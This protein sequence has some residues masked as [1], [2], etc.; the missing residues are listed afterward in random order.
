MVVDIGEIAPG[1]EVHGH[2]R[3]DGAHKWIDEP[4]GHHP[5]NRVRPS[6]HR[7]RLAD[8]GGIAAELVL[9]QPVTDDD[10]R[11]C[12]LL[13]ALQRAPNARLYS[14]DV[15]V[16]RTHAEDADPTHVVA[17]ADVGPGLAIRAERGDGPERG[18]ALAVVEEVHRR[19]EATLLAAACLRVIDPNEL[20]GLLVRKRLEQYGVDGAEDGRR[21]TDTDGERQDRDGREPGIT[22][23]RAH[24]EPEVAA[25]VVEET[26]TAR[27]ADVLLHALDASEQERALAARFAGAQ[28]TAL[29]Q[30]GVHLR[31][32]PQL[33]GELALVPAAEDDR[34]HPLDEVREHAHARSPP[35]KASRAFM[36]QSTAADARCQDACSTPS[37]LRPAAVSS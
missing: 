22:Q 11:R 17:N 36:T 21:P 37:C 31:V 20:A 2:P 1:R 16:V 4:V 32:K 23:Q 25:R 15:E 5:R 29:E 3:I 9:P 26:R 8:G 14:H 12:G 34:A 28:S 27:V 33:L 19:N 18:H 13:I 30:L 24:G 7:Q 10:R 35:S 6:A